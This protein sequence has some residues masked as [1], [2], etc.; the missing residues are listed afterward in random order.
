VATDSVFSMDGDVA[1]LR[2]LCQLA[3]AYEALVFIDESHATGF[4]GATGR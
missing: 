1:P 4:I 3:E 2:E